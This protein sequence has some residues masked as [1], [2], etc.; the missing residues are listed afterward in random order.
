LSFD[1][2]ERAARYLVKLQLDMADA[3]RGRL[4]TASR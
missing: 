1:G 3:G 4:E 2:Q